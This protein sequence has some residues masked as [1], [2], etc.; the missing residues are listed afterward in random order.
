MFVVPAVVVRLWMPGAPHRE[1][2]KSDAAV[3][4][5][6][7]NLVIGDSDVLKFKWHRLFIEYN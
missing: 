3:N 4:M 5:S 7:D 1:Q 2:H 6:E